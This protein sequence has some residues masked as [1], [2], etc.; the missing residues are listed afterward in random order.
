[1]NLKPDT[2]ESYHV[3]LYFDDSTEGIAARLYELAGA[4]S[5]VTELG[6]FHPKA[7]GP[8]PC[9]QFQMKTKSEDLEELV[10]WIDARRS[11]L[12]V[13]IHPE[14]AND[15]VAHTDLARWLGRRRHLNLECLSGSPEVE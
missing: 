9:R 11:G 14:I 15:Y 13:L 6:R 12:D 1:M 2:P 10:A 7:V 4:Y 3:H 5:I 8:H